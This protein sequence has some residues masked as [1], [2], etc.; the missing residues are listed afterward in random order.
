MNKE[1]L[2]QGQEDEKDKSSDRM[3]EGRQE[4]GPDTLMCARCHAELNEHAR[5]QNDSHNWYT[6]AERAVTYRE[7]LA[8]IPKVV[9]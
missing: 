3:P 2:H 9:D 1:Q 5:C 8:G 7:V 4:P 6:I